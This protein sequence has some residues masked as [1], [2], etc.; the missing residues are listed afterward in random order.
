[1]VSGYF[2]AVAELQLQLR[3]TAPSTNIALQY[4]PQYN[5]TECMNVT[6]VYAYQ[7]A[8]LLIHALHPAGGVS[9]HHPK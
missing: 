1:M 9:N 5:Y 4:T 2:G 6:I 7:S 3:I 8:H